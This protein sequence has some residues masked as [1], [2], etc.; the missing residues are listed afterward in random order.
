MEELT[1]AEAAAYLGVTREAVDAAAREG[2][3]SAVA[4]DG[5]RRFSGEA[6]E[7]FHQRKQA[8]LLATLARSGETPVSVAR[9]VRKGLHASG[10]TGLPRPFAAKLAAMPVDWRT[11]FNKAELAAACVPDGEGCRWC[12]AV[13]FG[14]FLG[15]RPLEFG[16][17]RVE[18]FGGQP[19]GVCGPVLL[20]PFF[21]AL[22]AR[23][24]NGKERPSQ[25]PAAPSAAVREMAREWALRRPVTASAQP[26]QDDDGR[27]MVQRRLQ[28]TRER[29][30]AAKRRGDQAHAIRLQQTLKSLTADASAI[31][32]RAS[33]GRR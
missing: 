29:L 5:P 33:R 27:S 8:Q 23:V 18:L 20:R 26:R 2:R 24:H 28:E 10:E 16:E 11:L 13:E 14:A 12:R 17:A 19:C 9:R 7:A 6:V 30:K 4:G 1:A 3:L 32:G 15:L 31:D 22:R 25:R 21:E